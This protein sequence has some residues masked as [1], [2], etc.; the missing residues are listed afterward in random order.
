MAITRA[1]RARLFWKECGVNESTSIIDIG[2]TMQFW[3]LARSLDLPMPRRIVIVNLK[4]KEPR[5]HP[6]GAV[7]IH[8]DARDLRAFQ[9]GQFDIAFSNSVIEHL[10]NQEAQR[11]MA[12][13]A[14]RVATTYWVQ[15][16]DPRF[17]IE[18]HYMAPLIHWLPRRCRVRLAPWT[19]WGIL[20]KPTSAEIEEKLN[21]LRLVSR[22]E[23]K[24]LFP[25]G[26]LITERFCGWPKSLIAT[27]A[28]KMP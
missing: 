19:V 16:P 17:L 18:P 20:E 9:A 21:E 4:V 8:G 25:D 15:T 6:G 12:T 28:L 27:N 26:R 10:G 2:G 11:D 22:R 13:E 23:M 7:V 1:K 24:E 5:I 3:N 14:R